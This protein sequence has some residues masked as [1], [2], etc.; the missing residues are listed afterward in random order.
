MFSSELLDQLQAEAASLGIKGSTAISL[1]V[2]A[3]LKERKAAGQVPDGR[4]ATYWATLEG[5]G[6]VAPWAEFAGLSAL[7][8]ALT[9]QNYAFGEAE[10]DAARVAMARK[11]AYELH[12]GDCVLTVRNTPPSNA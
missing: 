10:I 12:L 9:E 4:T 7:S 1:A 2:R 5:P 3:A 6:W 8:A 11:D